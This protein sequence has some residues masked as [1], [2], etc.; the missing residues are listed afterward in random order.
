MEGEV[1]CTPC[2][3]IHQ[4]IFDRTALSQIDLHVEILILLPGSNQ[5]NDV[6][7]C[8]FTQSF[9]NQHFTHQHTEIFF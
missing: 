9:H 8:F 6:R 5:L 2:G 3:Q 4:Q 7:T 1:T